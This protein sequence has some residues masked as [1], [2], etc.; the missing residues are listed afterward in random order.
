MFDN[1]FT[2][3]YDRFTNVR[4]IGVMLLRGLFETLD[5]DF[6]H[7]DYLHAVN[8]SHTHSDLVTDIQSHSLD[9]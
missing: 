2:Y 9:Y 7:A 8:L 4:E 6:L 1:A 5:L 3:A